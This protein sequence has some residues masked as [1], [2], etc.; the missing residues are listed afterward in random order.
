M[1]MGR[2]EGGSLVIGTRSALFL[3]FAHLGL[4]V[5]DE[6]HDSSYKQTEPAPRYHAR[7]AAIM[8]SSLTA[9]IRCSEAPPPRSKVMH[10]PLRASSG[11]CR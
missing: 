3:P 9:A 6:E 5:V 1:R 11:L 2:S 8:L 10:M 7:D 4:V